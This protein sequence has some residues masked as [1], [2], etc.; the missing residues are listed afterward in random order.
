MTA[1]GAWDAIVKKAFV[2]NKSILHGNPN[3]ILKHTTGAPGAHAGP[4]GTLI[5]NDYDGDAYIC[6]VLNTT[7]VKINA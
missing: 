2:E 6:T 4:V 7:W 5:W 1:I 3:I